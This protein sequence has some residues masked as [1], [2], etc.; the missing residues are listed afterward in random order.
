MDTQGMNMRKVCKVDKGG[1]G[2]WTHIELGT[3]HDVIG[4]MHI[5]DCIQ[6]GN[7][8]TVLS[9]VKAHIAQDQGIGWDVRAVVFNVGVGG[10][11]NQGDACFGQVG[12]GKRWMVATAAWR[13]GPHCR[14][15]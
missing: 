2:V 8:G 10:S 6:G 11:V 5:K 4:V 7:L 15:N 14:R 3:R 12:C 9:E 13:R 1:Q